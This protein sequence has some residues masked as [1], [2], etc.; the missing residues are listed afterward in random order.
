MSIEWANY[1]QKVSRTPEETNLPIWTSTKCKLLRQELTLLPEN[2]KSFA[3]R[4]F[5]FSCRKQ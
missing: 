3:A 1:T 4:N 2:S 5:I